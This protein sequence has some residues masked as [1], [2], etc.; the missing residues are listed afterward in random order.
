MELL[1]GFGRL[2]ALAVPLAAFALPP[3]Q[4]TDT[5]LAFEAVSIKPF[6]EGSP[7]Q[8]SGCMGGPGTD[9]PGR[10][11]CR[12][13]TLKS[14]LMNA[15]RVRNQEISGPAWIDSTHFDILA[16][17]PSGATREQ[18]RTMF[19]NLLAERFKVVLHHETRP[20]TGYS[21]TVA[22]NGPRLKEHDSSAAAPDD[23]PPPGGKLPTGEDGFPILRP[24]VLLHGP[25]TLFRPGRARLQGN[26]LKLS[27]LAD[28]L[29][30]QL[31]QNVTNE[32]GLTGRYDI[33]L[34]WAPDATETAGHSPAP[35][36]QEAGMP[37]TSLFAALERQ[38]GL[39]LEAKKIPRDIL[40]IDRA[41]KTP[42]GN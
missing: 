2:L 27:T 36:S 33:T 9:D 34:Y 19:R 5:N 3:A 1:P 6:P 31:D 7:I 35:A 30:N 40:V 15:Y 16:K 23:S 29:T 28:A 32:T 12:Y 24:S 20:M 13:M 25:I 18:A 8:W 17:V 42:T 38:L 22:K 21:L 37:E 26:D 11:D 10:Y 14:L 41:E 4:E 39:K